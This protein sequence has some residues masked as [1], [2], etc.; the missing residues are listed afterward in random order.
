MAEASDAGKNGD[1]TIIGSDTHFKGELT[2]ERTARING[3]FEGQINGQGELHVSEKATCKADV[4]ASTVNV[5]GRIEGNLRAKDTVRLNNSGMVKGD[6]VAA[7]MVMSEGA[8]FFGQCAVGP[9]A[10]KQAGGTSSSGG[11]Q[12]SAGGASG[13]QGGPSQS[14]GQSGGKK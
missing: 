14:G 5:D 6:I 4:E 1:T 7:K 12:S 3:K 11:G 9:E 10:M 13:S 2:F 8:S